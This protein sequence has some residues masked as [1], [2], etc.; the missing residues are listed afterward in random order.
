MGGKRADV[1]WGKCMSDGQNRCQSRASPSHNPSYTRSV[2]REW[3]WHFHVDG[4]KSRPSNF[5]SF[6]TTINFQLNSG[7]PSTRTI[8]HIFPLAYKL[9]G[10]TIMA[11]LPEEEKYVQVTVPTLLDA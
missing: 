4:Y 3:Q 7:L 11:D 6:E 1:H 5:L 8:S 10:S 2:T 9:S